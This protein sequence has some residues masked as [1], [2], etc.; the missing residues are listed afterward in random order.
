MNANYTVENK[1]TFVPPRHGMSEANMTL[2]AIYQGACPADMKPG[3]IRV[4]GMPFGPGG[5]GGA[6]GMIDVNKIKNMSPEERQKWIEQMQK[7]MPGGKQ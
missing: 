2:K 5:P 4:Q 7:G 3:D 6:G 1:M